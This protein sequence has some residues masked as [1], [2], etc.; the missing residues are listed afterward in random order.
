MNTVFTTKRPNEKYVNF[1]PKVP[2][3]ADIY[4]LLIAKLN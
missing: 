4:T 1:K 3:D 2:L